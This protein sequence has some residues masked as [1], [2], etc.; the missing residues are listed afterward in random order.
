MWDFAKIQNLITEGIEESLTL[1]YKG[2]GALEKNDRKKMEITKDVSAMANSAGGIIIYGI[3]EHDEPEKRHLPE[4]IDS[5]NRVEYSKEWLEQVISNI[6]PKIDGLQIYPVTSDD[7]S[8]NVYIVDIPQ[9]T[10]AHQA[11]DHRY[12]KRYNFEAVP[13]EDYEVKDVIHRMTTALAD[14]TFDF[15]LLRRTDGG[16]AYEY[17]LVILISNLGTQ[18][19]KNFKLIFSFP[20]SLFTSIHSYKNIM[21]Y[22]ENITLNTDE[23]GNTLISYRSKEVIFPED[24]IDINED[25][26]WC[27]TLDRESYRNIRRYIDEYGEESKVEW[28]LYADDMSPLHGFKNISKL[29]NY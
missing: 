11:T 16:A 12:Y 26:E 3:K 2:A 15:R 28:T 24:K 10:T 29:H 8:E 21:P 14:V 13:M 20:T 23:K 17:A 9:S 22:K 19:I 27:Y 6:R 7:R 18:V 4:K 1:E 25:I 5:V